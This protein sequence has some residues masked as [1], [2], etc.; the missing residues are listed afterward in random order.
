MASTGLRNTAL[1]VLGAVVAGLGAVTY[2]YQRDIQQAH[3]RIASGSQIAQTPCGP[4]EYA[5]LGD[6]LPVLVVHGAGGGF[7]QGLD[8][9]KPLAER[10]F[11]GIAMSRFGYLRTPFA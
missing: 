2:F 7:D 10:G 4:I 8:F 6:G 1:V 5:V 3:D 11:R 9:G